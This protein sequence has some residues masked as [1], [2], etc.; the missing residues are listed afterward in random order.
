MN[1]KIA[2]RY[3]SL[4]SSIQD[5]Y[6]DQYVTCSLSM[7]RNDAIV[8]KEIFE[9]P[10]VKP[11]IASLIFVAQYIPSDKS[12]T[13]FAFFLVRAVEHK[14]TEVAGNISSRFEPFFSRFFC[15]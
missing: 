12:T 2:E 7:Q 1:G 6:T 15:K 11:Y 10:F 5:I 14:N 13:L 9:G 3:A 4:F 8:T